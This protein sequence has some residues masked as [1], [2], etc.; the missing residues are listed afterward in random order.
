MDLTKYKFRCGGKSQ[1]IFSL[2]GLSDISAPEAILAAL[3][4][5]SAT[6][7][8]ILVQDAETLNK[9]LDLVS[10]NELCGFALESIHLLGLEAK[11]RS[12]TIDHH[13]AMV[14][15][16]TLIT[17]QSALEAIKFEKFE[18]KFA[19]FLKLT[20]ILHEPAI[21]LK[22]IVTSRTCY[23]NP[24]F[25]LSGDFD[26]FIDP[27]NFLEFYKIL[28]EHDFHVITGDTGF[29]NQLGVGPVASV[30]DLFLAPSAELVPSAVF[31]FYRNRWPLLD[32]KFNPLDRGLKM[33]ELDRFKRDAKFV[34]W[35]DQLF[36]APDLLD[37]LM[38]SL[39]HFEKDRL[40]G[41]KQLL[42]IKLLAEK[43]NGTPEL[44]N[45]FV[46]RSE[47]EGVSTACCAGLSLAQERLGLRDADQ[48]VHDLSPRAQGISQRLFTF[49]VTPLFY[50]NASSV[51]MLLANA[52]FSDDSSRKM[53]VLKE[54]F[55][56][57]KQFLS[58]YYF[59]GRDLSVIST[60][61][62]LLLHWLILWLPGGVVRRTFGRLIWRHNQFGTEE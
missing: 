57:N 43:I 5:R 21:W 47:V 59:G 33:I 11:F 20:S 18:A 38:I 30:D 28:C 6:S 48:V 24:S 10:E 7:E 61:F 16:L 14:D 32:I 52:K 25:R 19:S 8:Q 40:I 23:T 37:Q 53:R 13:G 45:E 46:R 56:P 50:W 15:L 35:R 31:G 2:S 27:R 49:T 3:L 22:G 54:S 34:Q 4:S 60:T 51:P 55:F 42:D 36:C 29:C 41:W 39:T 12:L 26:C 9:F 17:R 58:K 62:A 44:W 1:R